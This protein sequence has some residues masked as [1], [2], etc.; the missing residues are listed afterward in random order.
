MVDLPA[1]D[2]ILAQMS[3][4]DKD[5]SINHRNYDLYPSLLKN[6]HTRYKDILS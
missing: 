5:K 3:Q 2:H 4:T 1:I 6:P